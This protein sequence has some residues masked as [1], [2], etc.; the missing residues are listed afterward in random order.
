MVEHNDLA[1]R[2]RLEG[3][4]GVDPEV[5]AARAAGR[6]EQVRVL[7]GIGP[8]DLA[9]GQD[10]RGAEEL[11]AGEPEAA[12][13]EAHTAAQHQTGHADAVAPP[14]GD[15][16]VHVAK[17]AVEAAV[18]H[19][20]ADRGVAGGSVVTDGADGRDIDR[21]APGGGE[22]AVGVTAGPCDDRSARV[23][24][25]TSRRNWRRDVQ[26]PPAPV[27]NPQSAS[28]PNLDLLNIALQNHR[29]AVHSRK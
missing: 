3:E 14:V 25:R 11:I 13:V 7:L 22:P 6:P 10:Q 9:V 23:G 18:S 17:G 1:S 24:R 29:R 19:A 27:P 5:P 26:A 4:L 8:Y 28:I 21:D 2:L 12:H 20:T 16:A 15:R